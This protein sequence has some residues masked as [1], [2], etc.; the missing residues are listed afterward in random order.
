MFVC[1]M[2]NTLC[3]TVTIMDN[4]NYYRL[5]HYMLYEGRPESKATRPLRAA[6]N[7][8]FFFKVV[9]PGIYIVDIVTVQTSG[10]VGQS[11]WFGILLQRD[12]HEYSSE[13]SGNVQ[14]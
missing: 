5:T 2:Y 3:K 10:Q 14:E 8:Y 4:N 12:C 6:G 7:Y 9:V 13:T 11:D 1:R